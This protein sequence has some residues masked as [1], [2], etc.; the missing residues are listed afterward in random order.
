MLHYLDGNENRSQA[1]HSTTPRDH[2]QNQFY[3]AFDV[4]ISSVRDRFDQPSF[5]VFENLESLL[6]KTLKGEATSA[7]MS[8][9]QEKYATDLNMSDLNVELTTFKV[10]LKDK[11][12]EHFH[13]LLKKL[14]YWKTQRRNFRSMFV[15]FA[16][17]WQLTQ[18]LVPQ[19]SKLFPW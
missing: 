8:I 15:R 13:N 16:E 17:F 12:T 7:E 11:Q 5:F 1:H 4:L 9:V 2:Y 6:I 10:L 3:Q 14:G 18:H 19:P